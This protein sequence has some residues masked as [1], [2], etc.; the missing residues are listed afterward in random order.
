MRK[1]IVKI[2]TVALVIIMAVGLTACDFV[3][4][5]KTD[6]GG[7][8]TSGATDFNYS[9][10]VADTSV[11]LP[12]SLE[13]AANVVFASSSSDNYA[14]IETAVEQTGVDRAVVSIKT[15]YTT[16]QG[17]Y[18]ASGS[19][20]I[21]DVTEDD[22]NYGA[23]EDNVFYI[24]TCHH[25]INDLS[26]AKSQTVTVYVPDENGRCYDDDGYD[27]RFKFT[28]KIGGT[29]SS[30]SS[31]SVVLVG[32]DLDSD[33]AV[34]RLYVSN[35]TIAS[36]IV[37]AK[38]APDTYKAKL[39]ASVF[40]IGNPQ[41]TH[42][43]WLS[44]GHIS[45]VSNIGVV[46]TAGEMELW[47]IDVE[48]FPGNSGGGLFNL[49][50]ELIGITSSGDAVEIGENTISQRLN[51]AIPNA[52]ST[53]KAADKGFINV[54]KQLIASA[55]DSNYGYVSGR[56][57]KFGIT[58]ENATG[59]VQITEVT[60][61]GLGYSAGLRSGDYITSGKVNS[62]PSVTINS[63]ADFDSL[64]KAAKINDTLTITL[65]RGAFSSSHKQ[66]QILQYYFC[67]TQQY[68]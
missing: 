28:G 20:V 37:K 11:N 1:S 46:E 35:N 56:R 41:G 48:I 12:D 13:K 42:A 2:I 47:G 52:L 68:A 38:V 18:A 19:G 4:F 10:C 55:T 15:S 22:K 29:P 63:I 39:G 17:S 57:V 27:D 25:V 3:S 36:K 43:G 23:D 64:I 40:A 5:L 33:V 32:G 30:L 49:K 66:L 59:S 24:V 67:N 62:S 16:N 53:D 65:S 34:L 26:D 7:G 9:N 31:Q 50:G 58:V 45:D 44:A 21:I 60:E 61:G 6:Q 54:A 14:D 8:T 51:Y